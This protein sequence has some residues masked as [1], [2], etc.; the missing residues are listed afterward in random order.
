MKACDGGMN[1]GITGALRHVRLVFVTF[2]AGVIVL[3]RDSFVTTSLSNIF[4]ILQIPFLIFCYCLLVDSLPC[5][6][7]PQARMPKRDKKTGPEILK[8]R[9][10]KNF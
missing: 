9:L 4:I 3:A 5:G 1:I 8:R 2:A 7:T 6:R 10:E